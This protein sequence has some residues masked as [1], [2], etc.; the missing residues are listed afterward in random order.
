MDHAS[1]TTDLPARQ[2]RP[3]GVMVT[4]QYIIVI[5]LLLIG[6]EAGYTGGNI[7]VVL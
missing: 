1:Y 4:N 6:F 5:S 3:T 2:D 7:V